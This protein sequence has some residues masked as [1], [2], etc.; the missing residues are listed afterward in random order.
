MNV[1]SNSLTVA[2]KLTVSIP[3]ALTTAPANQDL[4]EMAYSVKVRWRAGPEWDNHNAR[5][6]LS[7]P[8]GTRES[9]PLA[10]RATPILSFSYHLLPV[11]LLLLLL[12]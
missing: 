11:D 10:H 7:C 12:L 3:W 4:L 9:M 1:P 5:V 6:V 2:Q 8:M